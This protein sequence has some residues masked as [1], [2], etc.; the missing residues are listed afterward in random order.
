MLVITATNIIICAKYKK[1]KFTNKVKIVINFIMPY[2]N[3]IMKI[4]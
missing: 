4:E 3:K 1:G 2:C